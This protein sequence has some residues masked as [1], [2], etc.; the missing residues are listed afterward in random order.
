V[1]RDVQAIIETPRLRLTPF[2][3]GDLDHLAALYADPAV[4]GVRKLG[5]QTRAESTAWL[6]DYTDHWQ[7]RGFGMWAVAERADGA[8]MG[9]CG[10]RPVVAGKPEIELSYGLFPAFRGRGF[11]TEAARAACDFVFAQT[12]LDRVVAIARASNAVSRHI[13]ERLGFV[14][15]EIATP[16]THPIARYRLAR[17]RYLQDPGDRL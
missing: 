17:E 10:F 12:S 4:M 15:D 11:A 16:G 8:F 2:A 9:E 5:V 7:I 13:L 1:T 3:A 6:A 14:L